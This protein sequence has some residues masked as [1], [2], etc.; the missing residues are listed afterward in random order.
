M[1]LTPNNSLNQGIVY[2]RTSVRSQRKKVCSKNRS[3]YLGI[4]GFLAGELEVMD[5]GV[6][7]E[8]TKLILVL[9]VIPGI[10]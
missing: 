1:L 7:Q 4:S 10:S 3:V 2:C 9:L 6:F 5:I 8:T